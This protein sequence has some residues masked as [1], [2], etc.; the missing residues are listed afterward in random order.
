ME[1]A[2]GIDIGGTNTVFGLVARDGQCLYRSKFK[3]QQHPNLNEYLATLNDKV[4]EAVSSLNESVDIIGVGVGAPNGNFYEGTIDNAPNLPWKGVIRFSNHL[5]SY[6]NLPVKLTNDANA[7]ALGEMT[8]GGAK[9]MKNFIEITLGT[10]LGSGIVSDGKLLYG[11][12][13]LA[14]EIGHTI[15]DPEGRQCSCGRLG[16]LETYVSA[17]GIKRTVL[18]MLAESKAAS[19]LRDYGHNN[20]TAKLITK[21]AQGGD[22]IALDAFELAGKYLGL[23][24][25]D[26]VAHT[27]PEAFFL[28]GGL[29]KA[30]KYILDPTKKYFDHFLLPVYHNKIKILPS[31]LQNESAGI[32]GASALVW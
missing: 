4:K 20:L 9:G 12:D 3:T 31:E 6:L 2:I 18:Q 7:A 14:G 1:I 5:E 22:Q 30:G 15:V 21:A 11:H 23:K 29:A 26:A 27:S 16:C 32:L 13:G 8:F 17:T 28:F 24:L 10:G 25:A 19:P